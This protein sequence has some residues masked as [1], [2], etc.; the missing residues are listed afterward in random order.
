MKNVFK[1][2]PI[3]GLVL[4]L[5][6]VTTTFSVAATDTARA[7]DAI[8]GPVAATVRSGDDQGG[9]ICVKEGD[10]RLYFEQGCTNSEGFTDYYAVDKTKK[11]VGAGPISIDNKVDFNRQ[12]HNKIGSRWLK[13]KTCVFVPYGED[14]NGLQADYKVLKDFYKRAYG[15]PKDIKQ[16]KEYDLFGSKGSHI[17][18]KAYADG[19]AYVSFGKKRGSK[20][21]FEI[22]YFAKLSKERQDLILESAKNI[23]QFHGNNRLPV[24]DGTHSLVDE[25][26]LVLK[27]NENGRLELKK[28]VSEWI[29]YRKSYHRDRWNWLNDKRIRNRK[30]GRRTHS[31]KVRSRALQYIGG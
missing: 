19:I 8:A 16:G 28:E 30:S 15:C 6:C 24:E 23:A 3:V 13:D 1:K 27:R 10:L 2:N 17:I 25:G 9:L 20:N 22:K 12:I 7:A 4:G 14:K 11:I 31:R 26:W 18:L 29:D 5:A 21:P